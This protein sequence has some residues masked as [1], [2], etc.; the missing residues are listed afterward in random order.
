MKPGSPLDS[1]DCEKSGYHR[2]GELRRSWN[3]LAAKA[4]RGRVGDELPDLG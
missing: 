1:T 3:L 4:V 2:K